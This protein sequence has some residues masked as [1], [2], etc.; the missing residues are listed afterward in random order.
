MAQIIEG[1]IALSKGTL[2]TGE[3][4]GKLTEGFSDFLTVG[5][6]AASTGFHDL[7]KLFGGDASE[8]EKFYQFEYELFQ[9]V[10]NRGYF[11]TKTTGT[12]WKGVNKLYKSLPLSI[13]NE[14]W[15]NHLNN[16]R[17]DTIIRNILSKKP[18]K[19]SPKKS[20]RKSPK[21]SVGKGLN[22]S[23]K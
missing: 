5:S 22:S 10:K 1:L 8:S 14:M 7:A 11:G 3:G 18:S 16:K 23:K 13:R 17:N 21:K 4:L 20:P 2:G 12:W 6:K 19:K 9:V 15:I